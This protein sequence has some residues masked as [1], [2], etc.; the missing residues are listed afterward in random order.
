M[1][2]RFEL[3]GRPR[4][5]RVS[6]YVDPSA[7][8]LRPNCWSQVRRA[9]CKIPP[10]LRFSVEKLPR[11]ARSLRSFLAKRFFIRSGKLCFMICRCNFQ[12]WF[13]VPRELSERTQMEY[14][15]R[16]ATF[17]ERREWSPLIRT[18]YR[19]SVFRTVRTKFGLKPIPGKKHCS[20]RLRDHKFMKHEW[21]TSRR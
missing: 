5:A 7:A 13:R 17:N 2:C 1:E 14:L 19:L 15:G 4:Q 12:R 10:N 11:P 21:E 9:L 6:F 3:R 16:H 8:A 18:I 20:Q